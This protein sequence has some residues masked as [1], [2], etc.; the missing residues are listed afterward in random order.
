MNARLD[1]CDGD[2]ENGGALHHH[3]LC[4]PATHSLCSIGKIAF[5]RIFRDPTHQSRQ[6]TARLFSG[7]RSPVRRKVRGL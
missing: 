3:A 2:G 4:P 6:R 5:R 7:A 1:R